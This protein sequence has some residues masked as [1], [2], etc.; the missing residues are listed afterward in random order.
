MTFVCTGRGAR[1]PGSVHLLRIG[2]SSLYT[3]HDGARRQSVGDA[4]PRSM[5]SERS[6]DG[7]A[8]GNRRVSSRRELARRCE[9]DHGWN[10]RGYRREGPDVARAPL[11]TACFLVETLHLRSL[12]TIYTRFGDWFVGLCALLIVAA[13]T[14]HSGRAMGRTGESRLGQTGRTRRVLLTKDQ[15]ASEPVRQSKLASHS[16]HAEPRL[17]AGARQAASIPSPIAIRVSIGSR[18]PSSQSRAVL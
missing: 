8:P 15:V 16:E 18:I 10:Q 6:R 11:Y 14:Y 9:G 3:H 12:M 5:V 13:C 17:P 2:L 7:A 1:V 4:Q